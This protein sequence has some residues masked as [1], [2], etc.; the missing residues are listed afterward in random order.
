MSFQLLAQVYGEFLT[1]NS[2][3]EWCV[4][5]FR[6]I[7]QIV[8]YSSA[9]RRPY[10]LTPEN[11]VWNKRQKDRERGEGYRIHNSFIAQNHEW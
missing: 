7:L 2:H 6:E 8:V 1:F 9:I 10:N 4:I 5:L 3:F 11:N